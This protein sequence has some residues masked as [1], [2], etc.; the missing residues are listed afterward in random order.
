[1]TYID[2]WLVERHQNTVL[3][4][5]YNIQLYLSA[6]LIHNVSNFWIV[7]VLSN[8]IFV[9]RSPQ[10]LPNRPLNLRCFSINRFYELMPLYPPCR[11][12]HMHIHTLE[13]LS[14]AFSTMHCSCIFLALSR[15]HQHVLVFTV[16]HQTYIHCTQVCV[17][18][19]CHGSIIRCVS[20]FR[21]SEFFSS[22]VLVYSDLQKRTPYRVIIR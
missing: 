2:W 4:N 14:N 5:L 18:V 1:M 7:T 20:N 10:R 9:T 6:I 13:R 15:Y 19:E 12:F 22:D 21:L 11:A 3:F 8:H 16:T 17:R